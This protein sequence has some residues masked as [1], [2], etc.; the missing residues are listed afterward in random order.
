MFYHCCSVTKSCLTLWDPIDC[1]RPGFSVLHHLP[2]FTEIHVHWVSDALQTSHPLPPFLLCSAFSSIR[3][4]VMDFSS[5]SSL[6]I[7][8]PKYWSFS[9]SPSSE[10]S[11]LIFIWIDR[12]PPFIHSPSWRL[13]CSLFSFLNYFIIHIFGLKHNIAV[14]ILVYISW[15]TC[16]RGASWS[17]L[18]AELPRCRVCKYWV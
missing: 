10:Y 18:G 16:T 12:M 9:V 13:D 2:E 15:S 8:W 5:E 4:M 3:K 14:N 1:S 7:R 6:H 17:V 11:G